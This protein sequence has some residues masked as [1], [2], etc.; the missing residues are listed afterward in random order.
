VQLAAAAQKYAQAHGGITAELF[1]HVV[2]PLLA[3]SCS[4]KHS[5]YERAAALAG[6]VPLRLFGVAPSTR[7]N[8]AD[9]IPS[10]ALD[11]PAA[12][13]AVDPLCLVFSYVPVHSFMQA[14]RTC[15]SWRAV[16]LH[17]AA[18]PSG[19][20]EAEVHAELLRYAAPALQL[21]ALRSLHGKLL[22]QGAFK[23]GEEQAKQLVHLLR[24]ADG[25]IQVS[26]RWDVNRTIAIASACCC[27]CYRRLSS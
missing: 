26:T 23:L 2:G 27:Y 1:A 5:Y 12:R 25:D 21:H 10:A 24:S 14:T 18:W 4:T 19:G 6:L 22:S 7:H 3:F 9:S 8:M 20:D 11:S 15:R 16:R 13:C 17:A